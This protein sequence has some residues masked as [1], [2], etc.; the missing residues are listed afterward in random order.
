M[1]QIVKCKNCGTEREIIRKWN[2]PKDY[3]FWCLV[4]R[5]EVAQDLEF[6]EKLSTSQKFNSVK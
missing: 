4:C 6:R 1:K 3:S 2:T 5:K